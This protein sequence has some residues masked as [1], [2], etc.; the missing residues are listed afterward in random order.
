MPDDSPKTP[1]EALAAIRA[2]AAEGRIDFGSDTLTAEYDDEI[3]RIFVAV[4]GALLGREP[5]RGLWT[6]DGEKIGNVLDKRD[7]DYTPESYAACEKA[8][9]E[10]GISITPRTVWEDAGAALRALDPKRMRS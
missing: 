9:R 6:A 1:E 4:R 5:P 7:G 10:L 8:S 3:Q 2:A